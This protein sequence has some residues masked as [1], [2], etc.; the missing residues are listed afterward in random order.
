MSTALISKVAIPTPLLNTVIDAF[1]MLRIGVL[2]ATNTGELL[3]SN[4]TATHI[5]NSA[6]GLAVDEKGRLTVV[7]TDEPRFEIGAGGFRRLASMAR[8][9]NGLIL[10]VARPS[11]KGTFTLTLR[12][13]SSENL[14]S[15]SEIGTCM[16]LVHDS[17]HPV[18]DGTEGIREFYGLTQAEA[19]VACLIM[20]GRTA[21]DCA[22]FLG[23]RRSTVKMH[24]QNLYGKTGVQRQAE[25]VALMF[26]SFG[27]VFCRPC[28]PTKMR[29]QFPACSRDAAC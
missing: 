3:F 24:L 9:R 11:G 25:L 21:E 10:S 26:K 8:K 23:V 14:A 2:L 16:V 1:D 17:E 12:P 6:D 5:L 18:L 27:N 13:F 29:P 20:E 7:A 28:V 15:E 22:S 19:R 4:E